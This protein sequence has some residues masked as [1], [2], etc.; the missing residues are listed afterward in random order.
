MAAAAAAGPSVSRT[1]PGEDGAW[2]AVMPSSSAASV[3]LATRSWIH[4]PPAGYSQSTKRRRPVPHRVPL[5]SCSRERMSA[6][7]RSNQPRA[8]TCHRAPE[9][10]TS[11]APPASVMSQLPTSFATRPEFA[12]MARCAPTPRRSI[13]MAWASRFES[14]RA[15]P[16]LASSRA[17]SRSSSRRSSAIPEVAEN[18]RS[19]ATRSTKRTS[20]AGTASSAESGIGAASSSREGRPN[21]GQALSCSATA[22]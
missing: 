18:A 22:V 7:K 17:G 3:K 5:R 21:A 16:P 4:S 10:S 1:R 14:G 12:A 8:R 13:D 11:Q 9:D 15:M 20:A 2:L 6:G 19:A